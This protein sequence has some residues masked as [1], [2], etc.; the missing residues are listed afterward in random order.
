MTKIALIHPSCLL[1]NE[2]RK[3]LGARRELWQELRLLT[4]RDDEAGTL[5]EIARAAAVV[6]KLEEGDLDT[7]DVAVFCGGIEESRPLIEALSPDATALVLSR[8][9]SSD[10]GHPLVAGVNLE[11]ALRGAAL[12][13]PHPAAVLLAHLL[14]PLRDFR[15]ERVT[16]TMLQPISVYSQEGLD[17]VFGQ[18]RAILR[19]DPTPPRQILPTQLAFNVIPSA[20]PAEHVVSQ[21]RTVL[22]GEPGAP[23]TS[24]QILQT[25]VFHS[26]GASVHVRLLEDPG[27]EQ[28]REALAEHP[29]I[30][31]AA[32]PELL[33]MIDAV[34]RDEVIVG[35]I[36]PDGSG[37][38]RIWAVMD[39]LTCGG[40]LNALQILESVLDQVV[41]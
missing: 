24:V 40:A 9:A 31:M 39:D 25:S 21:L 36:E 35:S 8:D 27:P 29:A 17:E 15:P 34:A 32:D 41:H 10:D 12:L 30:D 33:G 1:G 20:M 6:T 18:T 38:Y 26:Y 28:V 16:A 7:L 4:S 14:H 37:G 19:F 23:E 3:M 5:T 22:G 13:S 11:T 2:L